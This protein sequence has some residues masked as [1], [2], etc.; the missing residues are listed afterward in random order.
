VGASWVAV[1]VARVSFA[2]DV[3][4]VV[5]EVAFCCCLPT[6]FLMLHLGC[7]CGFGFCGFFC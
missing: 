6:V 7:W 3:A 5:V 1:G 4:L 2:T